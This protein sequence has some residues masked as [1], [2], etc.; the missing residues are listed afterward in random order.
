MGQPYLFWKEPIVGI[1]P[2]HYFRLEGKDGQTEPIEGV[3]SIDLVRSLFTE[4]L[5]ELAMQY[6]KFFFAE[7]ESQFVAFSF[8]DAETVDPEDPT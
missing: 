4:E 7:A 3:I 8:T 1:S 2:A 6:E 5:S